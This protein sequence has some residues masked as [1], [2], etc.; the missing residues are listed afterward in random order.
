MPARSKA[1][2]IAEVVCLIVVL[3]WALS[4]FGCTHPLYGNAGADSS[5]FLCMG[6][7]IVDGYTPYVAVSY[8]HLDVYKRQALGRADAALRRRWRRMAL[9]LLAG[10]GA[11]LL[12]LLYTFLFPVSYTHLDVYKRQIDLS[13][14]EKGKEI[15]RKYDVEI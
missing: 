6:R 12:S 1:Y 2:L 3:L 4:A 9:W 7:G 11:Y 10:L 8:T 14:F 5:I 13:S 15:L